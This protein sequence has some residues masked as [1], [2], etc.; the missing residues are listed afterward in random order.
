MK[1]NL[2]KH[3]ATT[4]SGFEQGR[5]ESVNLL[6][7]MMRYKYVPTTGRME[8]ENGDVAASM[9][10]A[11]KLNNQLD[12]DIPVEKIPEPLLDRRNARRNVWKKV[13]Q[14]KKRGRGDYEGF[15]TADIVIAEDQEERLKKLKTATPAPLPKPIVPVDYKPYVPEPVVVQT[16]PKVKIYPNEGIGSHERPT[17]TTINA[18]KYL[19]RAHK[20]LKR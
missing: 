14:N 12:K 7:D 18:L 6:R 20:Y 13:Q 2:N 3:N 4:L 8:N 1:K 10:E 16:K 5:R 19:K 17:P 15:S 11:V 9:A